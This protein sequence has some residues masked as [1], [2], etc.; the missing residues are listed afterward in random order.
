MAHDA[1][2][3]R[4][5]T[6]AS[7]TSLPA[8]LRLIILEEI[9]RQKHRGWASCAA[10]C[11]E[12]QAFIEEK[13]F[14]RLTLQTSCLD[15]LQY[16]VIRQRGLVQHICLNIKLPRY[17]CLSCRQEESESFISRN[18]SII[19]DAMV[20]LYSV[21]S[22]WQPAGRLILEITAYSP[23]DSQHWFKNHRFGPENNYEGDFALSQEATTRWH[24]PKHGWV[25][26]QQVGAPCAPAI[27]RIFS[28]LCL[29][30]PKN[31][32]EVHAVT[33]LVI[34]REVRRQIYPP[35]LRLLCERLPRLGSIVYEPWRLWPVLWK[36]MFDREMA[37][38]IQDALSS[39]IR[40]VSI[41][42]DS[43][44]QLALARR[45]D[46]VYPSAIDTNPVAD[47][48]LLIAFTSRSRDFE[49]L[50]ISYMIDARQFFYFCQPSYTWQHL[51]SLTLTSSILTQ[52][53]PRTEI[54]TLLCDASLAALNMPRLERMVFWNSK[55]GEACAVIYQRQNA[56]RQATLTWR[57]TW[58]LQFSHEVVESWQKVI[59]DSSPL[60]IEN[61]RVQGVINSHGDA[62][63]FLR[64]PSGIIHPVS[65][66]QMRQEGMMQT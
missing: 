13:N 25:N 41:F 55:Q 2:R 20:K 10:V 45:T 38:T 65:V 54:F 4:T 7:W 14:R 32:P 42:E 58:D 40:T 50:S 53:A 56:H 16:M 31:L 5:R 3:A 63:H 12:W 43:D 21:L 17:T 6:S 11:K 15:E 35:T 44:D 48:M 30:L 39:H 59:S 36:I 60:Q 27:L 26:G 62:I 61:E 66:W 1:K 46:T 22:T 23:S 33:G 52:T 29:F 57:G 47:H 19:R 64:L 34:R 49:H 8:E 37:S 9:S 28:P 51:Q 18:N 24:D